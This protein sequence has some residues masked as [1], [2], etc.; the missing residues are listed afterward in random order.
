MATWRPPFLVRAWDRRHCA[1]HQKCVALR[2]GLRRSLSVPSFGGEP[3]NVCF[4]A[5]F[6]R[7]RLRRREQIFAQ[8]R[9]SLGPDDPPLVEIERPGDLDLNRMRAVRGRAEMLGDEPAGERLVAAHPVAGALQARLES[10][11][12]RRRRA[13]AVA[14]AEHDVESATSAALEGIEWQSSSTA[15]PNHARARSI[16]AFSWA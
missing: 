3:A 1:L 12:D 16:R 13:R 6:L 5:E 7:Q 11:D 9:P 10:L 14:V 4:P 8:T 15:T 2:D